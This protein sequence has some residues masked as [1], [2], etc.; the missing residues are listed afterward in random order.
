LLEAA[1]GRHVAELEDYAGRPVDFR[2]M[3]TTRYEIA[4][5]VARGTVREDLYY[6]LAV[7]TIRVPPLREREDDIPFLVEQMLG[8][9]CAACDKP[10]PTVDPELMQYLVE[11]PWPGNGRE[12]RDCLDS[13]LAE[14]APDVLKRS[15][16]PPRL[17]HHAGDSDHASREGHVDTLADLE[18]TAVIQSLKVHQG[19]RTQAARSLGISVRTLQRK[20]RQW[21]V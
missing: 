1:E 18:R 21:A 13:M 10:V 20:L 8:G 19:N 7:V 16:F 4:D 5:S 6:R 12:L 2:L 3:A 11:R 15:H 14:G 9:L 17:T